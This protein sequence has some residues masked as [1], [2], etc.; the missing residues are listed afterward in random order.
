MF[1]EEKPTPKGHDHRMYLSGW[2][3]YFALRFCATHLGGFSVAWLGI[4]ASKTP[5]YCVFRS[6]CEIG[7][8][9]FRWRWFPVYAYGRRK[10]TS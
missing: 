2:A 4:S 6:L 1:L 5:F 3:S 8:V 10:A 9:V 7:T